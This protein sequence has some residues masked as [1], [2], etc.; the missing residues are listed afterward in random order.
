ML[1]RVIFLIMEKVLKLCK[2]YKEFLGIIRYSSCFLGVVNN[3][4]MIVKM[5]EYIKDCF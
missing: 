2:N 1:E 5:I 3:M 4:I